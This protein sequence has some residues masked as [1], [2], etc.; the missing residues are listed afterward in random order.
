MEECAWERMYG[1]LQ[2]DGWSLVHGFK[3]LNG[4]NNWNAKRK[5]DQIRIADPGHSSSHNL[6]LI[7]RSKSYN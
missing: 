1:Y 7:I 2:V 3:S 4:V 5:C 6:E